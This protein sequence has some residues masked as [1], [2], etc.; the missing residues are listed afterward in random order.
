[1]RRRDLPFI[2]CRRGPGSFTFRPRSAKGWLQIGVWAMLGTPL[3]VWFSGHAS[4]GAS[5]S[6]F[7]PALFLFCIGVLAWVIGGL[8][9]V[10]AHAEVIDH[11]V[12]L[13]DRQRA[14]REKRRKG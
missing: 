4:L 5:D 7:G 9:W 6:D 2:V 13:R 11:A 10:L 14:E 3:L 1:M 8:W 12:M